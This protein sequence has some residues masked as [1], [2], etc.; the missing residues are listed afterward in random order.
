MLR[1]RLTD[2][3]KVSLKSQDKVAV[4]TLR[5][6][7]A[8]LKDRDIAARTDGQTEPVGEAEI[9]KLLQKMVSQRRDS[10]VAYEKG[11]RRDLVEQ[12]QAE[13]RVIERFLPKAMNEAE[14]EAAILA[15]I[16]DAGAASIKDMGK[17]MALLRERFP[18]Q[19][20]FG[21][22]SGQVKSRLG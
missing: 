8:A 19:M 2:A 4:S 14:T 12:E 17:V 1:Q 20:D 5:L 10:I 9:L 3:L 6:I 16:A 7:L 15:A 13:I 21:K 11:G 22:A 18:G